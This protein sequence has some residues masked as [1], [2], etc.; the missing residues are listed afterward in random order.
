MNAR[1]KLALASYFGLR[2]EV[3][4]RTDVCSLIVHHG[5]EFVVDSADLRPYV[6][7]ANRRRRS[8]QPARNRWVAPTLSSTR[9]LARAS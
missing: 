9:A 4:I 6:K 2:V 5:R 8:E 3:A 1:A 7:S